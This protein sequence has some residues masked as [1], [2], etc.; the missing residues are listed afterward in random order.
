[1]KKGMFFTLV[2]LLAY[3]AALAF[4]SVS[5]VGITIAQEE[6]GPCPKPY[7]KTIFLRAGKPGDEVKIRGRRFGTEKGQVFFS[8]E[9]K[10]QVVRWSNSQIWVVIPRSATTGPVTV[11]RPCGAV[12]NGSY[13]K[14][15]E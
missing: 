2:F 7:I 4:P 5:P 9:V 3:L 15:T 1:M 12:S 14:V 13:F 10:A 8:P 11:S 6:I